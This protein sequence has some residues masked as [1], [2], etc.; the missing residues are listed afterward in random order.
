MPTALES[1]AFLVTKK[2]NPKYEYAISDFKRLIEPGDL[3][4]FY[5]EGHGA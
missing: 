2:L 1:I 5:L 4:L 3:L